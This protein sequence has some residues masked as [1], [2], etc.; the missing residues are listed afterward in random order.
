MLLVRKAHRRW[1]TADGEKCIKRRFEVNSI[2]VIIHHQRANLPQPAPLIFLSHFVISFFFFFFD[3][4]SLEAMTI[5]F[6]L[7]SH[8][9]VYA[10]TS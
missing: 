9:G 1:Q 6:D 3:F 10:V 7:S 5:Q 8:A 4:Q 2:S